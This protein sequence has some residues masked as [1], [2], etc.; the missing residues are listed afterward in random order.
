MC[1]ILWSGLQIQSNGEFWGVRCR[2]ERPQ[3]LM[4]CWWLWVLT[5]S[6]SL[7]ASAAE[8]GL[9]RSMCHEHGGQGAVQ[10]ALSPV[11]GRE[12][13][14]GADGRLWEN[15][16]VEGCG[17]V[18]TFMPIRMG[19]GCQSGHC[20]LATPVLS[21]PFRPLYNNKYIHTTIVPVGTY[22]HTYQA[23]WLEEFIG[24]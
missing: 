6:P 22:H 19:T 23:L 20:L 9:C 13:G 10:Q 21:H 8:D 2:T 24:R 4:R 7:A 14:V 11:S 5:G 1:S 18:G 12:R 15:N 16:C 3:Q 17:T